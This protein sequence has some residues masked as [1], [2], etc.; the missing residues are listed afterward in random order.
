MPETVYR[1][2]TLLSTLVVALPVGTNLGLVHLLW[3]LVSGRVLGAR[4]AVIPGVSESGLSDQAVRRGGAALGGGDGTSAGL[5]ARW[6][7][8]VAGEGHGQPVAHG[9]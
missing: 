5:L 7:G 4:G 2:M 9:G 8:V 1:M 3:M 6:E